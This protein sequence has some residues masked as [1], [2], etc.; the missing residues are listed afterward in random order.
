MKQ[1]RYFGGV[2]IFNSSLNSRI[3]FWRTVH[4][5]SEEWLQKGARVTST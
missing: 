3:T 4:K 1:I 5:P 2:A